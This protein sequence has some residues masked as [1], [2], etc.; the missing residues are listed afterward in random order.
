VG[1]VGPPLAHLCAVD[2]DVRDHELLDVQLFHVCVRLQ[3]LQKTEDD[4]AGL[5][6]PSTL[7]NSEFLGLTG[8]AH[9]L[10]ITVVRD[11]ALVSDDCLKIVHGNQERHVFNGGSCLVGVLEGDTDIFTFG[12]AG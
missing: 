6:G 4:L 5:L 12:L 10:V 2:L 9:G 8:T 3:I 1:S 7:S 11:A